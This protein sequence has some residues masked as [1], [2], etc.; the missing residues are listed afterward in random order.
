MK[1][2]ILSLA[3]ASLAFA[4]AYKPVDWLKIN[5]AGGLTV[6]LGFDAI[7]SIGCMQL[8]NEKIC[9]HVLDTKSSKWQ[10]RKDNNSEWIDVPG[11]ERIDSMCGFDS[12]YKD[13]MGVGLYRLV[14]EI[15]IDGNV[16]KYTPNDIIE[17]RDDSEIATA[18]QVVS[19][20]ALKSSVSR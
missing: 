17:V 15:S 19:W 11:S 20:G 13:K 14:V 2:I 6:Q 10:Y 3:L 1:A 4:D 7:I 9:D 18:I 16:G 12:S 8:D 5:Q